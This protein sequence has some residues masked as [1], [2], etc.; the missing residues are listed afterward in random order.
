MKIYIFILAAAVFAGWFLPAGNSALAYSIEDKTD[1]PVFGDF[2]V[3]P[4]KNEFFLNPGQ[5]GAQETYVINRMG[6]AMSFKIDIEDFSG[7]YD[8]QETVK[9]YGGERGPY[10]L[11]DYLKP[12]VSEFILSHGQKIFFKVEVSVPEDAEPG[13]RYGAIIVSTNPVG[14]ETEA[15]EG[16]AATGVLIKSRIASLF[17][18]RVRGDVQEQGALKDFKL[19][20]PAAFYDRG[21]IKFTLSFQNDGSVHLTPY[22][23]VEVT[24]MLGKNAGSA[25]VDPFF[26]MPVSLRTREISWDKGW[27]LGRYTATLNLNR[28]YDDIVDQ[29]SVS[30]WVI[31]W[32]ILFSGF[33]AIVLAVIF[34]RWIFSKFEI[35]MKKPDSG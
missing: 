12:E 28:G 18:V 21:P 26:A 3:G 24:N 35:R 6:R 31:P 23:V 25:E 7:S 17:F 27:L 10:S 33:A 30:F 32:K 19:V 29:K 8:P 4:T 20:S 1:I 2:V 14:V 11:K 9:Y 15:E 13:G 16:K 34:F 22:G 5:T